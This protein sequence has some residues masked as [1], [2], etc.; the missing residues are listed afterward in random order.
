MK[1]FCHFLERGMAD[2][3]CCAAGVNFYSVGRAREMCHTCPLADL[4]DG[5]L[6]EHL[7]VYTCRERHRG[8][9]VTRAEV[10]CVL[11]ERVP[12]GSR[13]PTCPGSERVVLTTP[14]E[15]AMLVVPADRGP[16]PAP[17]GGNDR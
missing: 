17:L 13:C 10:E 5:P 3:L 16:C 6:C 11:G 8:Y 9:W 7:E 14:A 1:A 2:E 4:G 12:D 15:A